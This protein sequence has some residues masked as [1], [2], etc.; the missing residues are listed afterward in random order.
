MGV[1][2]VMLNLPQFI[3][4]VLLYFILFFGIGF[5]LNMLLRS[6]WTMAIIY[7]IVIF[8]M[9]DDSGIFSYFTNAGESF[10][11]LGD[12]LLSLTAIDIIILTAGM[13][14]ALLSGLAIKMLRN[15]GYQ[16]F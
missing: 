6:T 5:I 16:M 4:A 7:P 13:I 9:V 11:L 12:G 8:F 3:I 2:Q 10:A 14:G 1:E 15:R